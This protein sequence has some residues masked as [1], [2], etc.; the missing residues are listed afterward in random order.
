M[1][2]RISSEIQIPKRSEWLKLLFRELQSSGSQSE[3]VGLKVTS[4]VIV[5]IYSNIINII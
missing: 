2:I 1:A 3:E 5:E 4:I